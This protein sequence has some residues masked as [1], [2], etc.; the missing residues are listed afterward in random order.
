MY[1]LGNDG[2]VYRATAGQ[3]QVIST[4]PISGEIQSDTFSDAFGYTFV[5]DNK[6]VYFLSLP[7]AGKSWLLFE[8]LGLD[9]W[10]SLT[11][12][13]KGLRFNAESISTC[14]NKTLIGDD[15]GDLNYLDFDTYDINGETWQRRRVISSINGDLLGQKGKRVQMSRMEFILETGVGLISGQGSDPKIMVEASYDGGKSWTTGSW[16]RVGRL[17]ETNIRAEWFS[18]HSF[19]DMMVRITTSDPVSFNLYSAAIDLRLAGR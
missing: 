16:C 11:K 14:Y 12:G 1:W 17:G 9:G 13:T 15:N 18:L 6:S 7:S 2:Q 10:I 19:Y 8:E 4:A 3:E 5:I